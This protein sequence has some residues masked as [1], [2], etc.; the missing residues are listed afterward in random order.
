[1]G[2]FL[3]FVIVVVVLIGFFIGF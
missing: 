3:L 2:N 1:V